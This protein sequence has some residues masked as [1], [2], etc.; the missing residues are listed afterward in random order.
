LAEVLRR[1]LDRD[2]T[3]QA[4]VAGS[5]DLLHGSRPQRFE[6]RKDAELRAAS[7]VVALPV[8]NCLLKPMFERGRGGPECGSRAEFS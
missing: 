8:D 6:D 5:V 2:I 4:G 3:I 7:E 1:H